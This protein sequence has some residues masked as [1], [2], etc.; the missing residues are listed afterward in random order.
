MTPAGGMWGK[1][2]TIIGLDWAGDTAK[3]IRVRIGGT[4]PRL[5]D[6]S[7]KSVSHAGQLGPLLRE[8]GFGGGKNRIH[9]SIPSR[10]VHIR[11]LELPYQ[12]ESELRSTLP[13]EIRR[14]VPAAAGT[15]MTV[16]HQIVGRDRDQHRMSVLVVLAPTGAAERYRDRLQESGVRLRRVEPAPLAA[17]NHLI[18]SR[19][20]TRD[21]S[22]W[23]L[24]EVG[25]TGSWIAL[26]REGGPLFV[27]SIHVGGASFTQELVVRCGLSRGEADSV[28]RADVALAKLRPEWRERTAALPQLLRHTLDQLAEEVSSCLNEYRI[29]NGPVRRLYL[30]GGG[31]LIHGIDSVLQSRLALPVH[32]IDPF[33]IFDLP[34]SW[35]ERKKDLLSEIGPQFLVAAGLTRWWES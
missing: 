5:C 35:P 4:H 31:A 1:R 27:R 26:A 21:G 30:A 24:L 16:A 12:N 15:E 14:H 3:A 23:G 13:F 2:R 29:R 34:D 20:E 28:K 33:E 18:H 32:L 11:H 10:E 9:C 17:V 25:A 8:L 7:L 22:C 6:F 19:T